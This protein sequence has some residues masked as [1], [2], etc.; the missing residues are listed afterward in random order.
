MLRQIPAAETELAHLPER[1]V[2][3]GQER[4]GRRPRQ[5]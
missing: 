2:V 4:A 5:L 1:E 3:R